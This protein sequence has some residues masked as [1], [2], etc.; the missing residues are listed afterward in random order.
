[1]IFVLPPVLQAQPIGTAQKTSAKRRRGVKPHLRHISS[2][3]PQPVPSSKKE[4]GCLPH[5]TFK[6]QI[7]GQNPSKS[8]IHIS[9]VIQ[10]G[11][12]GQNWIPAQLWSSARAVGWCPWGSATNEINVIF[13]KVPRGAGGSVAQGKQEALGINLLC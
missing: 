9:L 6:M 11:C 10:R 13:R 12:A 1:M 3:C 8:R 4:F 5:S 2:L 7:Q